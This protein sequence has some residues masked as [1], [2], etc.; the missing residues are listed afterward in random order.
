MSGL[1]NTPVSLTTLDN[2]FG[3]KA[4]SSNFIGLRDIVKE[5]QGL[6]LS[7]AEGAAQST[8]TSLQAAGGATSGH[9]ITTSDKIIGAIQFISAA[10]SGFDRLSLRNDVKCTAE[11]NVRF[12]GG[13]TAGSQIIV[14]WL[15]K[16]GYS[17]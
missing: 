4:P 2:A 7:K 16:S 8:N 5:L 10:G 15:D 13:S 11:G 12:T 3:W 1:T 9:R 17:A 6:K 14:L